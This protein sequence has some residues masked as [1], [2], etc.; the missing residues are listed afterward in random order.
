MEA[1]F[2]IDTGL[3]ITGSI[4]LMIA[5]YMVRFMAVAL[6]TY[7]AGLA[8]VNTNIDAVARTLGTPGDAARCPCADPAPLD[9]DGRA[10]RLRRRDEGTAG[11][12]DHAA[13]QLRHAGGAG[14]SPRRGRTTGRGRRAQPR[15]RG[16][17]LLPVALLCWSLLPTRQAV[18]DRSRTDASTPSSDVSVVQMSAPPHGRLALRPG[19]THGFPDTKGAPFPGS[20]GL[21]LRREHAFE[22]VNIDQGIRPPV[23][24]R[25]MS[26]AKRAPDGAPVPARAGFLRSGSF[27]PGVVQTSTAASTFPRYR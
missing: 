10:D 5:A 23:F 6:N 2:G 12:P 21:F 27:P 3:L 15:H 22:D 25:A 9:P 17:R 19:R 24:P 13:L 8:T 11:D 20:S 18:S 14:P 4:W 1:N 7:D 26:N 16:G